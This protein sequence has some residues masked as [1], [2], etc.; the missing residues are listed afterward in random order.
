MGERLQSEIHRLAGQPCQSPLG[1]AALDVLHARLVEGPGRLVVLPGGVAKAAHVPGGIILLNRALVEDFE[2][3][4]VVAGYI[5]AEHSRAGAQD[6]L[7]ALL[8]QSGLVTAFRLLTTGDVPSEDLANFAKATITAPPAPLGESTLLAAFAA[9]D[10]P[11]TP[12]AYA[13]DITGERTVG[14]IEADSVSA[15][16]AKPLLTDSQWVSLQAIC[17]E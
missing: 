2:D 16:G 7:E 13:E 9:A 14:L 11:A 6:P 8:R 12:Y 3:P 15:L 1:S 5:L 17:G 10:V 4:S